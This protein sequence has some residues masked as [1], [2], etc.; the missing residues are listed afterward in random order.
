MGG[1][2]GLWVG[3][4]VGGRA[5]GAHARV[6]ATR[7]RHAGAS[8]LCANAA[9]APPPP[10]THTGNSHAVWNAL[11]PL[12]WSLTMASWIDAQQVA[13]CAAVGWPMAAAAGRQGVV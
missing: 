12:V 11:P 2:V 1:W 8:R 6:Y 4:W 7:V 13:F 5:E 9:P 3:L 10:P